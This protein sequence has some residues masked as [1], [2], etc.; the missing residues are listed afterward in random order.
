MV[1]VFFLAVL[2][3]ASCTK[4]TC[5]S[6]DAGRAADFKRIKTWEA[7]K[8]KCASKNGHMDAQE[9]CIEGKEIPL[10]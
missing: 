1:G 2:L 5:S 6:L 7:K 3:V 10:D 8:N 4:A 9:R